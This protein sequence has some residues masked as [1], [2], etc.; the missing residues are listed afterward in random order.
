MYVASEKYLRC[1]EKGTSFFLLSDLS[2]SSRDST[3]INN[4][5]RGEN[6]MNILC[7][8]IAEDTAEYY[9][10]MLKSQQGVAGME[11]LKNRSINEES[12]EQFKLGF[13][14][15]KKD[16]LVRYLR[17]KGHVYFSV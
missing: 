9:H 16:G 11:Y 6:E 10:L 8:R 4:I 14:N 3:N 5:L 13:A 17:E 12:I 7:K 15:E 2:E 1:A